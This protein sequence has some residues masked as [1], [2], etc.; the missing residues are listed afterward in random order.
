MEGAKDNEA[1]TMELIHVAIQQLLSQKKDERKIPV[2]DDDDD[3]ALLSKLL[4]KLESIKKEREITT[5][6]PLAEAK[7][8]SPP[9][10][11]KETSDRNQEISSEET[12]KELRE[13]KRQNRTTHW[14]LSGVVVLIAVWQFSEVSVLL[15]VKNKVTHPFRTVGSMFN[16][17]Q[18]AL[19]HLDRRMPDVV[20][21]LKKHGSEEASHPVLRVPELP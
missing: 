13:V 18:D 8:P 6:G 16:G 15:I 4:S 12:V 17:A 3:D 14:L 19:K 7:E 11:E 2:Q 5:C 20:A 9:M 1:A 21:P 10:T